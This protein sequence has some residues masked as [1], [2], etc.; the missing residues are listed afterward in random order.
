M[1][2]LFSL[3]ILLIHCSQIQAL[4]I[5]DTNYWYSG[6]CTTPN[7]NMIVYIERSNIVGENAA[8]LENGE[9]I[10]EYIFGRNVAEES[11]KNPI[12]VDTNTE[13]LNPTER[14]TYVFETSFKLTHL[15]YSREVGKGPALDKLIASGFLDKTFTCKIEY[16]FGA[17]LE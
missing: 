1:K 9:G 13:V 5:P 15:E 8:I 10:H 16:F 2:T 14:G 11:T 7:S 12:L 4:A 6:Q 3:A 17:G